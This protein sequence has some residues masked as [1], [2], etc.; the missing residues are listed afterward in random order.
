MLATIFVRLVNGLASRSR[1]AWL[2]ARGTKI[3]GAVWLRSID[4][5]R[6]HR[7]IALAAGAAL[8][9]GV[10][11]LV[12]GAPDEPIAISIGRGV[13]INRHAMLDACTEILIGDD[14]MIGPFCYI[15]DHDHTAGK[16]G[17]PAS[18][19]LVGRPVRIGQRCWLGAHVTVLKGVTIGDGAVVGAGAVV[20][21]DVA[22][23]AR[24]A[25]VPARP[26]PPR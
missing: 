26:L 15:T 22:P 17:R 19:A 10:T 18:G 20:T 2:R 6:H 13:Y 12:S 8:D 25:G 1:A 23:G 4:V 16:D 11:L 7:R 14:T 24:V 5:P 21:R 9:R 3:S